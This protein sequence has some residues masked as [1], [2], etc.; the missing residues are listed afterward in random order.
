METVTESSQEIGIDRL[1]LR[2]WLRQQMR[3]HWWSWNWANGREQ[4][5]KK[6]KSWWNRLSWWVCSRDRLCYG[7]S[8]RICLR[9]SCRQCPHPLLQSPV[10]APQSKGQ[11]FRRRH[12]ALTHGICQTSSQEPFHASQPFAI[13]CTMWWS[14]TEQEWPPQDP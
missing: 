4:S 1:T 12:A 10:E 3:H 13:E 14:M 2:T 5:D 7:T 11:A 8:A 6:Q 9:W